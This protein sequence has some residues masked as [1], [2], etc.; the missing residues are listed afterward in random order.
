MA[1]NSDVGSKLLAWLA[2]GTGSLLAYS[3]Y[4]NRAPWDVLR[5]INGPAIAEPTALK[6]SANSSGSGFYGSGGGGSF[7]A[8]VPRIRQI[9]N[10]EIPPDLVKIRPSGTLDRD[11]AASYERVNQALGY[12][13]PNTGTYR[14]FGEQ[15]AHYYS[16]NETLSDGSP[17]FGNPNKSLHVVGLAVDVRADYVAKPEVKAALAAE[18]WQNPRPNAE[19]WH[20]S[21]L[22]RG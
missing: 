5:D 7:S 20:W 18:G 11:A 6:T 12:A 14:S 1:A 13:L 4:K 3:A 16:N 17:R 10:R 9:A 8:S 2:V 19:P 21:Y 22:V 15:S